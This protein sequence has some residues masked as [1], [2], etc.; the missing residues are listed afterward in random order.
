MNIWKLLASSYEHRMAVMDALTRIG[1]DS[2][3]TPQGLVNLLTKDIPGTENLISFSDRDLPLK[4]EIHNKALNLTVVCGKMNIPMTLVDNGSAINVCP[5]L[6]GR[7]LGFKDENFIPSSQGRRAYDNSRRQALG[8][9][10]MNI[11]EGE[12]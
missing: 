12:I 3:T 8:T 11:T 5:L 4:G 7:K 10:V 2:E 1:V 6:T 9:I